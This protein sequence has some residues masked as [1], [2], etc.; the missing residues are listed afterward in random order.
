MPCLQAPALQGPV[1]SSCCQ[2]GDQ[3]HA[4]ASQGVKPAQHRSSAHLHITDNYLTLSLIHKSQWA[5]PTFSTA[6]ASFRIPGVC[7]PPSHPFPTLLFMA[8]LFKLPFKSMSFGLEILTCCGMCYVCIC[9]C[10]YTCPRCG[11]QVSCYI[12]LCLILLT[13]SLA[14]NMELTVISGGLVG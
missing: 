5:P 6:R 2:A 1:T 14:L 3:P 11:H 9:A 4:H 8:E 13:Q 12:N 7:L 10:V